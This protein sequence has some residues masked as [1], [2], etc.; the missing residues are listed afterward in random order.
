MVDKCLR[1]DIC[2]SISNL[3]LFNIEGKHKINIICSNGHE[4]YINFKEFKNYSKSILD[5]KQCNI[6][7]KKYDNIYFCPNFNNYYCNNCL[8]NNIE[9]KKNKHNDILSKN[10]DTY[11]FEHN[12]EII[13]YCLDCEKNICK[14]CPDCPEDYNNVHKKIYINDYKLKEEE[15]KYYEN[16]IS[17]NEEFIISTKKVFEEIIIKNKNYIENI[18]NN[19]NNFIQINKLEI[20]FLKELVLVNKNNNIN[21]KEINNLKKLHINKLK[22]FPE[23]L[24]SIEKYIKKN[25]I[26]YFL[27][28][29]FD[30]EF[31]EENNLKLYF[32]IDIQMDNIN[33]IKSEDF[34]SEPYKLIYKNTIINNSSINYN[35]ENNQFVIFKTKNNLNLLAYIINKDNIK[36]YLIAIYNLREKMDENYIENLHKDFILEVQYFLKENEKDLIIT[37]SKDNTI[38]IYDLNNQIS[39]ARL[40]YIQS[41]SDFPIKKLNFILINENNS[42]SYVITSS[43]YD[44]FYK[45]YDFSGNLIYSNEKNTNN[46]LKYKLDGCSLIKYYYNEQINKIDVIF[47]C[48]NYIHVYDLNSGNYERNFKN[49]NNKIKNENLN[50]LISIFSNKLALFVA[51]RENINIYNYYNTNLLKTINISNNRYLIG[52]IKWNKDYIITAGCEKII[53]IININNFEIN[54]ITENFKIDSL[55]KYYDNQDKECLFLH[56]FNGEIKKYIINNK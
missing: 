36:Q 16:L 30:D 47:A 21:Y 32:N 17:S 10:Y 38:N 51:T 42:Q 37:S 49:I 19:F 4:M 28:K 44:L 26:I 35:Y 5:N 8:L 18:K 3:T 23:N 43:Y 15:F 34:N 22:D 25:E 9:H 20:E 54:K 41:S 1:C 13:G 56:N 40:C 52:L 53:Y 7:K 31:D 24:N 39:L 27:D 14:N 11:C 29:F 48:I 33:N 46:K 12:E 2:K 45:I 50:I 6:C 55:Q